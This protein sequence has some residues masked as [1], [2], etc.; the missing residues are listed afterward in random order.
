[1][2]IEVEDDGSLASSPG[3]LI[4]VPDSIS[5]KECVEIEKNIDSGVR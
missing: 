3:R 4:H 2:G 5:L 1:M